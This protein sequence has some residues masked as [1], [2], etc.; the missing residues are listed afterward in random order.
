MPPSFTQLCTRIDWPTPSFQVDLS[1]AFAR[2]A[3]PH[4]N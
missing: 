3:E 1:V 2:L 4:T